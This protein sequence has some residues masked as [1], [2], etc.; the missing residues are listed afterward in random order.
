MKRT[1][2]ILALF[3]TL[4]AM[5]SDLPAYKIFN[6]KGKSVEFGKLVKA[7]SDVDIVLFGQRFEVEV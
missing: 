1:L 7:A 4:S 6:V 3:V 5:R 2:Y